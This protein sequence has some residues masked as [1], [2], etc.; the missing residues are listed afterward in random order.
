MS[1]SA[2]RTR[3]ENKMLICSA[4]AS[5]RFSDYAKRSELDYALAKRVSRSISYLNDN[6]L[7]MRIANATRIYCEIVDVSFEESSQ[8]YIVSFHAMNAQDEHKVET[9]RTD[10]VDGR[11]A[12][13]VNTYMRGGDK[14]QLI[15][16]H[17]FVYKLKEPSSKGIGQAV[18]ICPFIDVLD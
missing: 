5:V 6:S 7:P 2:V 11:N 15:G 3:E 12:E 1:D 4:L 17:A 16:K 8:R 9:I 14:S 10:R 13:I 18:R